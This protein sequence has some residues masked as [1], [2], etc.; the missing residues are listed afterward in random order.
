MPKEKLI[1]PDEEDKFASYNSEPN[2][3][4][5]TSRTVK[6]DFY[7]NNL[8]SVLW[9]V[10]VRLAKYRKEFVKVGKLLQAYEKARAEIRQ[11]Q[12]ILTLNCE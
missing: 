7:T 2:I 3:V 11:A 8:M 9:D 6:V 4:L 1:K 12:T 5:R 10:K